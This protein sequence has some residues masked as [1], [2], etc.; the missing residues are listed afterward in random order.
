MGLVSGMGRVTGSGQVFVLSGLIIAL[1][2]LST[3]LYVYELSSPGDPSPSSAIDLVLMVQLGTRHVVIGS[4]ANVSRGGPGQ[5]L[6]ENLERWGDLVREY[7]YQLGM[8]AQTFSVPEAPPYA[9]GIWLSWG[10]SG[11]G[12]SVAL[13]NFTLRWSDRETDL[14]LNYTVSVNTTLLIEGTYRKTGGDGKDVN[15]TAHLFNEEKSA[16]LEAIS[17]YYRALDEW[18]ATGP[19]NNPTLTD[20]GNGTYL[21]SFS[22]DI[23]GTTVEVSAHVYDQRGVYVQANTTCTELP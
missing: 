16:L 4:L 17:V 2:I 9:S 3:E 15:V 10:S 7:G 13:A 12:F 18:V 5:T 23:P 22:A 11:T 19:S 6:V 8:C 1:I 20:Y 14:E 21:Y